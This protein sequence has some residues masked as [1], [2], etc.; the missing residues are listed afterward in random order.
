VRGRAYGNGTTRRDAA[1]RHKEIGMRNWMLGVVGAGMLATGAGAMAQSYVNDFSTSAAPATLFGVANVT[2]GYVQLTPAEKGR[3]GGLVLPSLGMVESFN[4][5][6]DLYFSGPDPA[7][8]IALSLGLF[9]NFNNDDVLDEE[10][11]DQGLAVCF[12]WFEEF[13]AV[14]VIN[15]RYNNETIL[16]VFDAVDRTWDGN[17]FRRVNV[18]MDN[19]GRLTVTFAGKVVVSEFATGFDPDPSYRF[20]F[21]SR[22]GGL[23]SEQRIDNV[24]IATATETCSG[25]ADGSGVVNFQDITSVLANFGCD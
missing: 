6:F 2:N 1:I 10:G 3:N 17:L 18:S 7:D 11:A 9:S 16:R 8:G 14:A 13:P 15:I 12:D 23:F 4:A 22:T 5:S 19:Q 25:D 20:G 21:T 24:N